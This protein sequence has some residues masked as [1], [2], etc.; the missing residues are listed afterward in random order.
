V[1]KG[2]GK[3]SGKAAGK[4]AQASAAAP[5]VR[6][7]QPAAPA[8]APAFAAEAADAARLRPVII[9]ARLLSWVIALALGAGFFWLIR[10]VLIT[11]LFVGVLTFVGAPFVNRL[12][13]RM[14]RSAAAGL[15]VIGAICAV[16]ALFALVIPPLIGDLARLFEAFPQVLRRLAEWGKA[17][18]G[19]VLPTT[20]AELTSEASRELLDQLLPLA[21]SGGG[22]V[23]SSAVGVLK[24]AAGAAAI[25]A[26]VFLVPVL[27]FFVLSELPRVGALV[28]GLVPRGSR[29]VLA[30]YLPRI[31]ETLS[32]LIR[33]QLLVASIMAVIYVIGL[34]IS[35]VPFALAIA[36][37]SGAAYLVPFASGA[38]CIVLSAAFSLMELQGGAIPPLVGAL[39]T[40]VV[41]QLIESYFLTPR[42]VGA[43]AGLSPLAAVLAVLLG[44]A[45]AGFLGVVF[46]L[47][48]G[49]VIALILREESLR[50][51]GLLVEDA[52]AR[53]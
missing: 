38:V 45:A 43:E 36:V 49:A 40:V 15:F 7:T 12:E 37:L 41:V 30:H 46:A 35:G 27:A 6:R 18:F 48:T 4:K 33:G 28:A 34:S 39:I 42:I 13:R 50:R 53:T 22:L 8:P 44:G 20:I 29:G 51:G 21:K 11:L 47:P 5:A 25:I 2:S 32:K 23:K 16:V 52:E 19:V 14:P 31:H 3:G 26:Q 9:D 10:G 1:A 24:G 17:S